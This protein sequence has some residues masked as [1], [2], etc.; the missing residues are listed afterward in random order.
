MFYHFQHTDTACILL[1]L[2]IFHIFVVLLYT[3]L[4]FQFKS[5]IFIANLWKCNCFCIHWPYQSHLYSRNCIYRFSEIFKVGFHVI[6][7]FCGP[8]L[9]GSPCTAHSS[10]QLERRDE[11][12]HCSLT[13]SLRMEASS[14]SP[15]ET[16]PQHKRASRYLSLVPSASLGTTE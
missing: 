8:L 7:P 12:G 1:D 5:Q 16:L 10:M 15:W 6:F 14:L 9:P 13:P 4:L 3:V 11:R 2:T